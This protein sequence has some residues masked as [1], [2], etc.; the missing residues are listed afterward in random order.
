LN[1]LLA[2]TFALFIKTKNFHWHV[3]G[4]HF[5]EYRLLFDEEAMEILA[6]T[7]EIA[8]RVRKLGRPTLRSVG[9]I[10]RRQRLEDNDALYVHSPDM[11]AELPEDNRSLIASMRQ[12]HNVCSEHKDLASMSLIENYIDQAKS[13]CGFSTKASRQGANRVI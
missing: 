7:G 12:A 13:V 10:A 1:A 2:E 5:R 9:D 4:P 6:M 11:L 3:S 8:E